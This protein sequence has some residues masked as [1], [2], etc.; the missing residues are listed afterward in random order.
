MKKSKNITMEIPEYCPTQSGVFT[1]YM[2]EY[3][4]G[5]EWKG[6]P[7]IKVENGL[8]IPAPLM[9]EG[10]LSTIGLFGYEQA[11]SIAWGYAAISVSSYAMKKVEIRVQAYEVSFEIKAKK[12]SGREA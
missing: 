1:A 12:I 5:E 8:G 2:P 9:F 10:I 7:T 11:Q 6:V 3:L 4:D